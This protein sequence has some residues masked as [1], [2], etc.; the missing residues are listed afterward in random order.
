MLI[1]S[2]VRSQNDIKRW[3][4]VVSD[5]DSVQAP[6][7]S[8]AAATETGKNELTLKLLNSQF[9]PR[10]LRTIAIHFLI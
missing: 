5:I 3:A 2:P 10:I 8:N 7:D 6:D 4:S 9:H 1:E